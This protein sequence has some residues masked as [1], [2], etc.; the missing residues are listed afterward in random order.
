MFTFS[1]KSKAAQQ[2]TL[3]KSTLFSR[4]HLGQNL[5]QNSIPNVQRTIG[6]HSILRFL[7][8]DFGG[9]KVDF[10][11]PS[12]PRFGHDFS[13]ISVLT[14]LGQ[15]GEETSGRKSVYTGHNLTQIPAHAQT[16]WGGLGGRATLSKPWLQVLQKR[17]TNGTNP[18]ETNWA[19]A[20]SGIR[21][22]SHPLPHLATIQTY[23]GH[24]NISC[25]QA[26]TH[27]PAA[28]SIGALA[29][30]INGHVVFARKPDLRTAAHEAAHI[31]QQHAG[32]RLENGFGQV[33]DVY[34]QHAD[35]VADTV[36][37]GH[38][39]EQLLDTGPGSK[40]AHGR[41]IQRQ[42]ATSQ[43]TPKEISEGDRLRFAILTAAEGWLA[44]K[45]EIID[46]KTLEDVRG[47]IVWLNL[48]PYTGIDYKVPLPIKTPRKN[49][50]TCIEFADRVFREA[51]IAQYPGDSK[52]AAK[53]AQLL[54]GIR[55]IFNKE[56]ELQR[57]IEN[58]NTNLNT[59]VVKPE[60]TQESWSEKLNTAIAE[61]ENQQNLGP[62][63]KQ[64][65]INQKAQL[66]Q[67]NREL[68]KLSLEKADFKAKIDKNKNE[69]DKIRPQ[70]D[71]WIK[72]STDGHPEPGDFVLFG[73]PTGKDTYGISDE[74]QV[75][76]SPGSFNHICVFMSKETPDG[77]MQPW[78]TID[79]GDLTVQVH[80]YYI[81]LSDF[82]VFT[83]PKQPA[84]LY[85]LLGW[86]DINKLLGEKKAPPP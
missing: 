76:L 25:V 22:T 78:N 21:G 45:K 20:E 52:G 26:H 71:A 49:F 43:E 54:P 48:E 39:A 3:A 55:S 82:L 65:L 47:G 42:P 66:A 50:T 74:T 60:G 31:V 34:E 7:H 72:P 81:R 40:G 51:A 13:H 41:A 14:T 2:T 64:Q 44:G 17:S 32:V 10:G 75:P 9:L 27:A 24:H 5:D 85:M 35:R 33:G 83:D 70:G 16:S 69:L 67:V 23:F 18:A 12:I 57:T 61:L 28:Q 56:T 46:S 37:A 62:M 19:A 36:V 15:Q 73:Q 6:N 38:S 77:G 11:K 86:I 79:G 30:A 84:P 8:E 53:V 59:Y 29:Y 68:E 4:A 1:E 58:L 80:K 63:Q